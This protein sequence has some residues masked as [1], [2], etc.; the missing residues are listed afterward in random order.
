MD[1]FRRSAS[2]IFI[3]NLQENG[4]FRPALAA[5]S[6]HFGHLQRP[7]RCH[8]AA[9]CGETV[10]PHEVKRQLKST[11]WPKKSLNPK[12]ANPPRKKPPPR[13]LPPRKSDGCRLPSLLN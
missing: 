2:I 1:S 3:I 8:D 11:L 5:K 4:G 13:K 12:L 9:G 6:F 10:I 7:P